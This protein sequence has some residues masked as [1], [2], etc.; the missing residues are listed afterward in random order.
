MTDREARVNGMDDIIR[1]AIFCPTNKQLT[2]IRSGNSRNAR[3]KRNL[4]KKLKFSLK[5]KKSWFFYKSMMFDH[6]KVYM[7][8]IFHA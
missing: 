2:I 6:C 3:I 4:R 1:F 8:H 7:L 5:H